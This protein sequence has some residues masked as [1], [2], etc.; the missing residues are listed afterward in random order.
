MHLIGMVAV[1]L[2]D[3]Q[4]HRYHIEFDIAMT[5]VCTIIVFIATLLGMLVASKDPL[6]SLTRSEIMD[7]LMA[8]KTGDELKRFRNLS[9][10]EFFST[11][12][13]IFTLAIYC[14]WYYYCDRCI[15]YAL[16]KFSIECL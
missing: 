14:W 15:N 16:S 5:I 10:L 13:F 6:Y 11:C 7:I 3:D 2:K 1:S 9:L 4:N 12:M 8:N